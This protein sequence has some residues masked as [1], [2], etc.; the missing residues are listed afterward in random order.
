MLDTQKNVTARI[1]GLFQ[2]DTPII[3]DLKAELA[4]LKAE[5]AREEEVSRSSEAMTFANSVPAFGKEELSLLR[6]RRVFRSSRTA[7]AQSK[8]RALRIPLRE[9]ITDASRATYPLSQH[10]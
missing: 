10:F 7:K 6:K 8:D 9:K 4:Q 2:A 3:N 5:Y 1:R